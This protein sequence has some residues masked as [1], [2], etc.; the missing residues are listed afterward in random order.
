MPRL[1]LCFK[2]K[3]WSTGLADDSINQ[4]LFAALEVGDLEKNHMIGRSAGIRGSKTRVLF[5]ALHMA[6]FFLPHTVWVT[7]TL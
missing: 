6:K 5:F 1:G 7:P 2:T 4:K 3:Y